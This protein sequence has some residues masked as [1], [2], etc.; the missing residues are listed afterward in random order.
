[1]CVQLCADTRTC[2]TVIGGG[3]QCIVSVREY[4]MSRCECVVCF[5]VLCCVCCLGCCVVSVCIVFAAKL[6]RLVC[7]CAHAECKTAVMQKVGI[8]LTTTRS[9]VQRFTTALV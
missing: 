4:A 5:V 8:E 7:V 9:G 1:M 3:Q 6:E 2:C